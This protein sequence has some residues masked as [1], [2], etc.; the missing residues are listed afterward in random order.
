MS[1]AVTGPT[2][3]ANAPAVEGP[4]WGCADRDV[5]WE[6]YDLTTDFTQAR[7]VAA[8]HPDEVKELQELREA[9]RNRVL[10]LMARFSVLYGIL[11]PLPTQTRFAFAGGV[12]NIQWGMVPRIF[13]RSYSIE[14]QLA[15]PESG[16]EGVIVAMADFIGGFALSVDHHY[17][18]APSPS[19]TGV[20]A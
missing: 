14:A 4:S 18:L 12:D 3:T 19:M 16:A 13:G 20:A 7:N 17:A 10:P 11:P 15:V 2:I 9:E 1:S 6:L 5:G 8:A